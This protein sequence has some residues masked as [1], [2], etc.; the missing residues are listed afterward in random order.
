MSARRNSH[1]TGSRR[2]TDSWEIGK[3]YDDVM[4]LEKNAVKVAESVTNDVVSSTRVHRQQERLGRQWCFCVMVRPPA[5]A[6]RPSVVIGP[7]SNTQ[8]SSLVRC[9][10]ATQCRQRHTSWS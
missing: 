7:L 5:Q 8:R 2:T 3:F 4:T 6:W 9:D 10:G 1:S